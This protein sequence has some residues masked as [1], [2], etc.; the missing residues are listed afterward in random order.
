MR[1]HTKRGPRLGRVGDPSERSRLERYP[2]IGAWEAR[3]AGTPLARRLA[4]QAT[5]VP[6][7][8]PRYRARLRKLSAFSKK[9]GRKEVVA[10]QPHLPFSLFRQ[11]SVTP[12]LDP[13]EGATCETQNQLSTSPGLC[14][15]PT[16]LRLQSHPSRLSSFLILR[17]SVAR[18]T[19]RTAP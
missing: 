8:V 18:F 1:A 19:F 5:G 10:L 13:A 17:C 11:T 9:E 2:R 3:P 4:A 12:R 16:A 6:Y 14:A 15:S 7:W